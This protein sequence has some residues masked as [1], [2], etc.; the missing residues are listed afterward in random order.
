[1]RSLQKILIFTDKRPL[2][3]FVFL[4]FVHVLPAQYYNSGADPSGIKWNKIET[5]NF[6]L[7]FPDTFKQKGQYLAKVFE[8]IYKSGGASLNHQP[9]KISVLIHSE[10]AYSNGFVSWAPKR[11]ELYNN[12]NQNIY[13]QDWLQQLVLHEFRHVVQLDKLNTGFTKILTFILGE[14]A[15][16]AVLGLYVPLWFLEGDAVVAETALTEIGRGRMPGFEQEMRAQI[17][18][19]RIYP[20]EKAMFG[21][22]KDEV[23]DHYQMGYLFVAGARAKYGAAIWE[24]ALENTGRN[25]LGITPFN[26]GQKKVSGINKTR[27]YKSV[28]SDL[29]QNWEQQDSATAKSEFTEITK[30]NKAYY[31]YLYP[32]AMGDKGFVAELSGPGEISRFVFVNNDGVHRTLFVPGS[33]NKEPFSYANQTIC[34]AEL[35]PDLRWE[36]RMYSVIKTYHLPTKTLSKITYKSRYFSPALSPDGKRIAVIS[37]DNQ[38]NYRLVILDNA[39]GAVLKEFEHANNNYLFTPAWNHDGTKLVCVSLSPA[40][41]EIVVLHV[42]IEDAKARWQQIVEPTFIHIELPKWGKDE[43]IIFT[44]GFSGT[45]EIYSVKNG[46]IKQL[47]QSTFGAKGAIVVNGQLVYSN[48]TADGYQLV[49]ATED[50]WL[51]KSLVEVDDHSI[52]LH[53]KIAA[54]EIQKPDFAS[55]D[56]IADY[57]VKKYSK[58]N[59]INVHSWAPA[60]VNIDDR[61]FTPGISLMSQNLLGT[62]SASLGY[63]ADSQK[64]REKYY[65][66]FKYQAWYPVFQL[67]VKHGDDRI[68]YDPA[69]IYVSSTDTFSYSAN[70]KRIHTEINL[71]VSV[72]FNITRGKYHTFLQPRIKYSTVQRSGYSVELTKYTLDNQMLKITE[73]GMIQVPDANYQALEYSLYFHH[74]LRRTQ[75]D[76]TTRWG[77]VAEVLCQNTPFGNIDAGSILGLHSRLYFPGLLKHHSIRLEN[78]YQYK[79]MGEKLQ[80]EEMIYYRKQGDYFSLPRGYNNVPNDKMYSFRGDYIFP[81]C[82]PDLNLPGIF[83]LKRITTNLFYDYSKTSEAFNYKMGGTFEIDRSFSATGFEMLAEVHAFRFMFPIN[84]GYRYARLLEPRQNKHELLMGIN[85]S[86]FSIGH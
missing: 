67:E 27:L 31:N 57:K 74:L 71:D 76:V 65:F 12:P 53:E 50:N 63:N 56:T 55:L 42:G 2:L 23:P 4:L 17:M 33:R 49:Q 35:E 11:I 83:Y 47:T 13:A 81:L 20:Y 16:G 68:I 38:N 7:V 80:N 77:Q 59:L 62:A 41:K 44:A 34:W 75:R 72:S 28:F 14:Q 40:G 32:V 82:N 48:Y 3:L 84:V 61:E 73:K 43:E 8:E 15:V 79:T 39:T 52:K 69:N 86:G 6:K 85:I 5:E 10:T 29:K 60:F 18:E 22:Y 64:S 70:Q 30:P 51:N 1:M 54:Q 78:N 19:K 45:D 46:E 66:N 24:K 37:V 9:R 58:W 25:P 36:N 26:Q 21:S